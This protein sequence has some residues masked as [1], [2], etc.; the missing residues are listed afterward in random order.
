MRLILHSEETENGV[1]WTGPSLSLR[2]LTDLS[3]H[4][5][6]STQHSALSTQHYA[7]PWHVRQ[8]LVIRW[9]A[10]ISLM[11]EPQRGQGLPPRRWTRMKSRRSS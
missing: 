3:Q 4:S 5:A 7:L 1:V 9:L 10:V 6:L 8:K 2:V 11:F